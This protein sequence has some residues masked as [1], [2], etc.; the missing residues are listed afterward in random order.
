MYYLENKNIT[1]LTIVFV[2][3]FLFKRNYGETFCFLFSITYMINLFNNEF[4]KI[5]ILNIFYYGKALTIRYCY[6]Y[7]FLLSTRFRN[8]LKKTRV[9][10]TFLNYNG[11]RV[12]S[13]FREN[14]VT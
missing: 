3:F 2:H 14:N 8:G 7:L 5:Y 10:I 1:S 9:R 6:Y 4:Y 13:D 12:H 11:F